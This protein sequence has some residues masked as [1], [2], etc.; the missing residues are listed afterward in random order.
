M[1]YL[2]V[3]AVIQGI[4]EFLPVSSSAHLAIFPELTGQEDQ[5][6][7][8]DIAVH[9]GSLGAVILYNWRLLVR[10]GLSLISFGRIFS[11]HLTI[12]IMALTATIP[13]I[14]AGY[15][16]SEY[17]IV[18]LYLRHLLV[19][20]CAT[21][22]FGIVL[23]LADRQSGHR[24]LQTITFFDAAII[25]LAQPLAFIPGTSR[26]GICMTMAR[27]SGLSRKA[28]VQ[29]AM[30]LSIPVIIGA[31]AKSGT[32]IIWQDQVAVLDAAITAAGLAFITALISIA[33]MMWVIEK[34]GMMPFVIYRIILGVILIGLAFQI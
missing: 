15:F 4:T 31:S 25:G 10:M 29:F 24:N 34:L 33:I 12:T 5:G 21:L 2:A 6:L 1:G 19:I 17:E 22:F 20:G 32:D 30:I 27:I 8:I 3:L 9:F 28:S 26:S 18:E 14:S 23:G 13:A 16:I 11:D 7:L